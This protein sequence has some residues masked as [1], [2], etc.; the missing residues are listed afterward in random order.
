MKLSELRESN[1]QDLSKMDPE[2]I[3]AVKAVGTL[4]ELTPAVYGKITGVMSKVR[5]AGEGELESMLKMAK[6]ED[7]FAIRVAMKVVGRREFD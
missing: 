4:R 5:S 3:D 2:I 6:G 1:V 7:K